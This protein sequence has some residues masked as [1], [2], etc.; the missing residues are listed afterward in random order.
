MMR[1]NGV[2]LLLAFAAVAS[3]AFGFDLL[4][5]YE[6]TAGAAASAPET[7]PPESQ[8]ALDPSR[9]NLVMLVHPECPCSRASM[10]EL[11]KLMARA[12]THIVAHVLFVMPPGMLADPSASGMWET[13]SHIPNTT[14]LVDTQGTEARR[15]GA[16]TSGQVAL[17]GG[18]GRL[19]FSGGITAA[20]GHEG[21]SAGSVA[22]ELAALGRSDRRWWTPVFGCELFDR[23]ETR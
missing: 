8:I 5:R 22:V 14:P 11:A 15:L 6:G 21:D 9:A 17:Y 16:V 12:G 10:S 7:W 23:K 1:G 13:A 19:R 4:L 3:A 18:D 2:W 20:R